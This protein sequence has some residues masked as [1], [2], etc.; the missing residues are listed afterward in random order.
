MCKI[1]FKLWKEVLV[2]PVKTFKKQ[3]KKSNLTLGALNILIAGVVAGFFYGLLIMSG[4][5]TAGYMQGLRAGIMGTGVGVMGFVLSIVTFP[6]VYLVSWFITSGILYLF[7]VVLGGK[8]TF[9]K[10]SYLMALYQS[11]LIVIQTILLSIPIIGPIISLLVGIYG[12][13]LLTLALKQVHKVS[14]GKAIA[15]W[16]LPGVIVIA[17]LI[18]VALALVISMM[19]LMA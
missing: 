2:N 6:I 10:Q 1:D 18:I 9:T 12:L 17:L 15:I 5:S 4:F 16:L 13:Y 14:T 19:P 3:E 8:G 7:A 11:P